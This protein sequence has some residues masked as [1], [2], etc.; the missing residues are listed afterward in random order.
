MA[1]TPSATPLGSLFANDVALGVEGDGFLF[2]VGNGSWLWL[3]INVTNDNKK[4]NE[5][6]VTEKTFKGL[7]SF[8]GGPAVEG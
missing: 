7:R 4:M 3:M 6:N 2:G 1:D 5:A 8:M